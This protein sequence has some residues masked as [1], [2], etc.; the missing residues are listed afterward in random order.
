M[1]ASTCSISVRVACKDGGHTRLVPLPVTRRFFVV[2]EVGLKGLGVH[3]KRQVV[4]RPLQRWFARPGA[5]FSFH[6]FLAQEGGHGEVGLVYGVRRF[7][8]D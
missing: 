7:L 6:W 1:A 3:L 5:A 8:L 2:V 4:E